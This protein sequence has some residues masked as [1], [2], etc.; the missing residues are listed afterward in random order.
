MLLGSGGAWRLRLG[1][2]K[3]G[4]KML[5][6]LAAELPR[7]SKTAVLFYSGDGSLRVRVPTV[8]GV[9]VGGGMLPAAWPLCKIPYSS[10]F[11]LWIGSAKLSADGLGCCFYRF[12]LGWSV[13]GFTVNC[14]DL[15]VAA[16]A[17]SRLHSNAPRCRIDKP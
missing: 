14:D 12:C 15:G 11:R 4:R 6:M 16:C 13:K 8:Q 10:S 1:S 3:Q 17:R 7:Q 2:K 9:R 5:K